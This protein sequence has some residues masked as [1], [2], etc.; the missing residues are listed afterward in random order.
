MSRGERSPSLALLMSLARPVRGRVALLA[1]VVVLAQLAL[2]AGPLL[3]AWGTDAAL[4]AAQGRGELGPALVC[5]AVYLTAAIVGGVLSAATIKIAAGVSQSMLLD[6]RSRLFRHTQ[7]L[8]LEFHERYT[9]GRVISRQTSDT[10]ALRELLDGGVTALAGSALSMILTVVFLVTMDWPSGVVLLVA[11][12]PAV[13]VTRW[14]Q[15]RSSVQF[16]RQRTA[17][18]RLIVHFVEAMTGMRALQAFRRERRSSEDYTEL[19]LD[20]REANVESIRQFGVFDTSLTA[21][22][23]V[24]VALVLLVSGLRVIDGS[25]AI[26]VVLGSVMYARRFFAP[27]A[28]IGT[29]YNSLQSAIAALEK[30]SSLLAESPTVPEPTRPVGLA[31]ARGRVDFDHVEFG[32]GTLPAVLP[33]LDLHIPAGQQ[34][35]LVGT[36]GAGKSTIAKL[37]ARFYDVRRG[38]VRLDGVDLRDLASDDLRRAVVMVTQEAYLFSGSVAANI[39]IGNPRATRQQIEAAARAVGVHD[40]VMALPEGYDTPVDGRGVRLS[41]GQRQLVSFAR[42]FLADP[43]VLVLD[44]ATSS[45]DV[46]GERI[47]QEGLETLLADRTSIVIAH[48]LS[49]VMAADRVLVV[50]G[51]RIVEDGSPAELVEAGGHF[52]KLHEGWQATLG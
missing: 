35:A 45:L 40:V 21:I 41:A 47:V 17:S 1:V 36:T 37:V 39:A 18:A 26:G 6:L 22:G 43:A 10:E 46:P 20:Y 52:A 27:L 30:L 9:S 13:L 2:A 28:Q 31:R 8:D 42:A 5:S 7:R 49:T 11:L 16:R 25:M 51:G 12:V 44:E 4:A 19:A 48:R 3:I 23:N 29:F 34:V 38:S 50:E 33:D 14:F 24:T 15:Q 32:Y